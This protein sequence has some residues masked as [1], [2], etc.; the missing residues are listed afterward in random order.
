MN[1]LLVGIDNI[2]IVCL[3]QKNTFN[4]KLFLKSKL[5]SLILRILGTTLTNIY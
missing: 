3:I 2:I 1:Y 5:H 4:G